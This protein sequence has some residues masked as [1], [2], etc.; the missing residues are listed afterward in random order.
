MCKNIVDESDW[1]DLIDF[2]TFEYE[3]DNA[4]Y[5]QRKLS[6][7]NSKL[8][9]L[10]QASDFEG[11]YFSPEWIMKNILEYND[12]EIKEALKM[13]EDM[14]AE[15]DNMD[16]DGFDFDPSPPNNTGTDIK[17]QVPPSTDSTDD[18]GE[19]AEE[20]GKTVDK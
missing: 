15:A 20:T 19:D 4:F 3:N 17:Q 1:D 9:A 12:D 16:G 2:L 10:Q 18:S 14:K 13:R 7:I 11:K 8:A 6:E 5:S